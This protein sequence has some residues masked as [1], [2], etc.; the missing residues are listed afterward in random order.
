MSDPHYLDGFLSMTYNDD[1][2]PDGAWMQIMIDSVAEHWGL[3]QDVAHDAV[4]SYLDWKCDER[5]KEDDS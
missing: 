3:E 4:M 1:G 5:E 2:L